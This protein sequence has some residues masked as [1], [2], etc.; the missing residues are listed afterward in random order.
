MSTEK[1]EIV[2]I[3][4]LEHSVLR[5][6]ND[7]ARRIAEERDEFAK[8]LREMCR[9]VEAMRYATGLGKKQVEKWTSAKNSLSKFDRIPFLPNDLLSEPLANAPKKDSPC[10][11]R[12]R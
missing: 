6:S 7:E 10:G 5:A 4:K 2:T 11:S 8:H 9:I 1:Q 3:T 12:D